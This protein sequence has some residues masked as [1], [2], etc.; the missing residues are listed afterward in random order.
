[1]ELTEPKCREINAT[2]TGALG[3]QDWSIAKD[4][5]RQLKGADATNKMKILA[6]TKLGKTV[7]KLS[8]VSDSD[9][10]DAADLLVQKWRQLSKK[11]EVKVEGAEGVKAEVNPRVKV[12]MGSEPKPPS[13][14]EKR[15]RDEPASEVKPSVAKLEDASASAPS[16]SRSTPVVLVKT[17]DSVR[18]S[19]RA[20]LR[21]AFEKGI[22]AN[23]KLL[24]ELDIDSAT[25]SM[26][27]EEAMLARFGGV[28]K[29]YQVRFRSL[30]FNL[31]DPKN[32][33]FIRAVVL[34]QLH[35]HDLAGMDVKEMASAE[36]KKQ[37][38]EW[39]E[40]AKMA[41]MDEQT[42]NQYTGKQV[43]DGI[44]KCPKCKSMKT[45]YVEVQTRSA[46]EPT[47]KKCLCTE[48]TYRW[49]FC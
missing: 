49:K 47:T 44:L 20:K 7:F 37:R 26:E 29:E 5:L 23:A 45:S 34:G 48:C 9:V 4:V 11:S 40:H 16:S 3:R 21:E 31:K 22:E 43:Q 36:M 15:P 8:K 41:L 46:D 2:L 19:V 27:C 1:M 18:D 10:A 13:A 28:N 24:R 6:S 33:E 17:G 14:G 12:E 25:L 39:S 42:Y 35:V 30:M 38:H 32:P